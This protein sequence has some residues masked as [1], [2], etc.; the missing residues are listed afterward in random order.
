MNHPSEWMRYYDVPR[1]YF[2]YKHKG[3][4]VVR[5]SL[6]NIGKRFKKPSP[7]KEKAR[8]VLKKIME[9]ETKQI[10]K[11]AADK[12]VA[13]NKVAPTEKEADKIQ[14]VLWGKPH[15]PKG[16][17]PEVKPKSKNTP[18]SKTLSTESRQKLNKMLSG[19]NP[20]PLRA[21]PAI[22]K[23]SGDSRK[24]LKQILDLGRAAKLKVNQYLSEN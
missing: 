7:K 17:T 21:T 1:G 12:A 14:A 15:T 4:G 16:K 24:K 11:T 20:T 6:M 10:L 8:Q 3:T 13:S 19:V 22:T 5:D 18:R 9:D 23:L 2:R